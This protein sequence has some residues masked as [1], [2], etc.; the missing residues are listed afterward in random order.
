MYM[1]HH[2]FRMLHNVSPKDISIKLQK[3]FMELSNQQRAFICTM[4]AMQE[5]GKNMELSWQLSLRMDSK[6]FA[7]K[8]TFYKVR[9]ELIDMNV[10]RKVGNR[11]RYYLNPEFHPSLSSKWL[12]QVEEGI[13]SAI[14][15]E[16]SSGNVPSPPCG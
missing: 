5:H 2:G 11:Y 15:K 12:E 8:N 9:Q 16:A 3:R 13:A 1:E 4:I 14:R 6:W 10:I 7:S